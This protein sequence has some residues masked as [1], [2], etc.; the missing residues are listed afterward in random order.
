VS[1]FLEVAD[2]EEAA[3][4]AIHRD[5][6]ESELSSPQSYG[7]V[8]MMRTTASAP[9]ALT[10][11]FWDTGADVSLIHKLE[12][13]LNP[14][15]GAWRMHAVGT[16]NH[17]RVTAVGNMPVPDGN[18]GWTMLEKVMY[19]PD[20]CEPLLG[21]IQMGKTHTLVPTGSTQYK[22]V[23]HT[24]TPPGFAAAHPGILRLQ[25]NPQSGRWNLVDHDGSEAD[26]ADPAYLAHRVHAGL[27]VHS[28]A[29]W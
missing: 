5:V 10:P 9:T 14:R 11:N 25:V 8:A 23:P 7:L 22:L 16:D 13:L 27:H 12:F 2:E 4:R 19:S 21:G 1:A 15:R 20:I 3:R 6:G 29:S 17:F 18:G 26:F 28:S 24:K